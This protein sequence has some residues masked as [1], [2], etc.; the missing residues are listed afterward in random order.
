MQSGARQQTALLPCRL[1]DLPSYL[2]HLEVCRRMYCIETTTGSGQ[3]P[4]LLTSKTCLTLLGQHTARG[5]MS[6]WCLK[7][8]VYT[9]GLMHSRIQILGSLLCPKASW[10]QER[11]GIIPPF[12]LTSGKGQLSKEGSSCAWYVSASGQS[13]GHSAAP[14][15]RTAALFSW[16]RGVSGCVYSRPS[17]NKSWVSSLFAEGQAQTDHCKQHHLILSHAWLLP[18]PAA[19]FIMFFHCTITIACDSISAMDSAWHTPSISTARSG[20]PSTSFLTAPDPTN[21][22]AG[23]K[24]ENMFSI[25]LCFHPQILTLPFT[26]NYCNSKMAPKWTFHLL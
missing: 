2:N 25:N 15:E 23:K 24:V 21:I 12:T 16:L 20:S 4:A 5:C 9:R 26:F 18:S 3:N 6:S 11:V 1:L 7:G 22:K 14:P 19:Q 8:V 13:E 17:L 10:D